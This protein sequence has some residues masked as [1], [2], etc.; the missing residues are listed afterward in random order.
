M[1]YNQNFVIPQVFFEGYGVS[2]DKFMSPEV[3]WCGNSTYIQKEGI[4]ED[5]GIFDQPDDF[6]F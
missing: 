6:F 2:T 5:F 3:N 4:A 1:H